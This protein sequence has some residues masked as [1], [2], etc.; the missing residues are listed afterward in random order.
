MKL[1]DKRAAVVARPPTVPVSDAVVSHQH[2]Q[3]A[4]FGDS[5]RRPLAMMEVAMSCGVLD[6][7]NSSAR[8]RYRSTHFRALERR[9]G[10]RY[11]RTGG[12]IPDVQRVNV[13]T[14]RPT[15]TWVAACW[16]DGIEGQ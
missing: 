1:A 5:L 8:R 6:A 16:R 7:K 15:T 4:S 14:L 10:R 12:R 13:V 3:H 2:P 11:G 9:S